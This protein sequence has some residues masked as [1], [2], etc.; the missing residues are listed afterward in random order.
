MVAVN[1][2]DLE[3]LT[4]GCKDQGAKSNSAHFAICGG[5]VEV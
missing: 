4:T 5:Q 1:N 2:I 3:F